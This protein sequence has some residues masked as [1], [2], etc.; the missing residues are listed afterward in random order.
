M[1]VTVRGP[2]ADSG[3]GAIIRAVEARPMMFALIYDDPGFTPADLRGLVDE[4]WRQLDEPPTSLARHDDW[5]S[6]AWEDPG[7]VVEFR[8]SADDDV[9][10]MVRG[11]LE[12]E[13]VAVDPTRQAS[14]T[15]VGTTTGR[16]EAPTHIN[17]LIDLTTLMS[18]HPALAA[19]LAGRADR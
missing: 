11:V 15:L 2:T 4:A 1:T 18:D 8:W 14:R 10:S 12:R 7:L 19:S 9:R 6:I 5:F 3:E 16:L 17:F 13:G